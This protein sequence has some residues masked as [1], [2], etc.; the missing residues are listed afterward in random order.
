[1]ACIPCPHR[2]FSVPA[3]NYVKSLAPSED[4]L[5]LRASVPR[6]TVELE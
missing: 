3:V 1:M 6:L 5:T 4:T 2:D